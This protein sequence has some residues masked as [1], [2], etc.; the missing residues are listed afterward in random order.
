MFKQKKI[1]KRLNT[2]DDPLSE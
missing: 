2:Q 1:K